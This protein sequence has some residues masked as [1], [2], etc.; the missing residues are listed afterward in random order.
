[1]NGEPR[2]WCQYDHCHEFEPG[3]HNAI[4]C[5]DCKC[6][7]K[8]ES[9]AKRADAPTPEDMVSLWEKQEQRKR[10]LVEVAQGK[11]DWLFQNKTF[12]SF[13]IETTDLNANIGMM[14]CACIKH[15]G[16]GIETFVAGKVNGVID[17]RQLVIDTR[18]AVER[19]DYTVTYY[20][21][22]FDIPFLNTKLKIM[23]ERPIDSLRHIDIYYIAR[24]R[25]K[26]Y[27][28][29]LAVVAEALLGSSDKTRILGPV[30]TKAVQGDPEAMAYIVDHCKIDVVELEKCFLHLRGF[31]NLSATRIR[32]YGGSY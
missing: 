14:L 12:G 27:S 1:M 22:G 20:G 8:K 11:N 3:S 2:R 4:Y 28:N 18:D 29:R 19:L 31:I 5:P 32:K 26:L 10:G 13:D 6:K 21:T 24:H 9:A 16:G 25:L 17:D 23:G 30:Q 7:R 15:K